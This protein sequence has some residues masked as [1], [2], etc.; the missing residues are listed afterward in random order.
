VSTSFPIQR[1]D[2]NIAGRDRPT[3]FRYFAH[4]QRHVTAILQGETYPP[5]QQ[6]G[7]VRTVIDIGANV[8]SAA[9][10]FAVRHPE[11]V[12][13]AFEPG[14]DARGLLVLNAESF[15]CI[16]IHPVGLHDRDGTAR[17]FRSRWDPMSA[18][19]GRNYEN[20]DDSEVI[21]L[22]RASTYLRG[23]GVETIDVLKVDTEGCELP[24]LRDL[25]A[26]ARGAAVI[27]LEYHSEADRLGIDSFL[28]GSHLLYA[29]S[30]THPHRGD[31]T[32][33]RTDS[34]A[35]AH[36]AAAPIDLTRSP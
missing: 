36:W 20:S 23:I 29:A 2:V 9:I 30:A 3:E 7:P 1:L 14:A 13:H 17:L 34:G 19:I 5:V 18:S 11:A 12:I 33:V 10:Y 4:S 8:G 31:L 27:H 24:I 26:L 22:R 16:H 6:L 25:E 35:A 21:E 32:Y 28:R 15:P